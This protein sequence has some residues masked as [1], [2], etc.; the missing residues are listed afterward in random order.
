MVPDLLFAGAEYGSQAT[1]EALSAQGID[2]AIRFRNRPRG[3]HLGRFRWPVE[4]TFSWIK[5]LRRMRIHY[6]RHPTL[7]DAWN[8]LTLAVT[9]FR[10]FLTNSCE[11]QD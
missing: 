2:S 11:T 8:N 7:I 4:R 6:D 5:G 1:R 3:S 10:I 9:C